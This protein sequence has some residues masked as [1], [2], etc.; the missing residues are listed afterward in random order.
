MNKTTQPIEQLGSTDA[1]GAFAACD[2]AFS[3]I[4]E[5]GDQLHLL[6]DVFTNLGNSHEDIDLNRKAMRGLG[7]ALSHISDLVKQAEDAVVQP[8]DLRSGR[9]R[10]RRAS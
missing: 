4:S 5:A 1:Y 3:Y 2:E 7:S 6:S 10:G 9:K 8:L